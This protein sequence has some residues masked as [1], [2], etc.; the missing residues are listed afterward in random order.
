M[1]AITIAEILLYNRDRMSKNQR[2]PPHTRAITEKIRSSFCLRVIG[3]ELYQLVWESDN[4]FARPQLHDEPVPNRAK[5]RMENQAQLRRGPGGGVYRQAE[6]NDLIKKGEDRSDR[7]AKLFDKA[8]DRSALDGTRR[9][10][11]LNERAKDFEIFYEKNLTSTKVTLIQKKPAVLMRSLR[12]SQPSCA[13][14]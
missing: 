2:P 12:R 3:G 4:I 11:W 13:A 10:D 14:D 5:F 6:V 1:L 9:E 7:S 8:L